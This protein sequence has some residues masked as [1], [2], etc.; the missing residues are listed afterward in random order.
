MIIEATG[1]KHGT[2]IKIKATGVGGKCVFDVSGC[3]KVLKGAYINALK[4]ELRQQH[5]V[6]GTY[7][8]E[9]DDPINILN[10]LRYYYFEDKPLI[11][12]N[13]VPDMPYEEGV[14]Y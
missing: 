8:P 2:T 14:I 3:E 12:S 11:E 9:V 5:P 10:V 6:D 4:Q 13:G 1:T 7:I